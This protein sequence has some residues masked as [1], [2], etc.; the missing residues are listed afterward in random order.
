MHKAGVDIRAWRTER[1]LTAADLA[2]VLA[3]NGA[4]VS[5]QTVYAWEARGKVARIKVMLVL[6][7]L[8]ICK[9]TDWNEPASD[10]AA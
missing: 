10:C 8:G 7:K 2:D 9:P 6:D 4:V 1:E 3:R 5:P